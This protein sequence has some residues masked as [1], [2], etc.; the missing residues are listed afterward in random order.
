MKCFEQVA[1]DENG[2]SLIEVLASIIIFGI[3][4]LGLT[5]LMYQNFSA[6]DQNEL[7]ERAFYVRD[8]IK[9]WLNYKA[10]SQDIANLNQFVLTLPKQG[11]VMYTEEQQVRSRYL[12]VDESGI[13]VDPG[14]NKS[15]FGEIARDTSVDRGKIVEKVHYDFSGNQLPDILNQD[16][17]NKYYMGEYVED[18]SFL[19][20]ISAKKKS[21]SS[22]EPRTDG[23]M[24]TIQIYS[25]ETGKLLTETY[26]NWVPEY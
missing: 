13:Q 6:I 26:T 25:K 4:L 1:T 17:F 8:D 11:E 18:P 19:V 23:M 21:D 22:Y 5:S 15:K 7:T 24:L 16:K 2:F 10:Q 14:T 9:E 3:A 20:K 12:I